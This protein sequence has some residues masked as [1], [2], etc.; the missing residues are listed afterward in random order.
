MPSLD[1]QLLDKIGA[2]A[3]TVDKYLD[4]LLPDSDYGERR[5]FDAMRY[6][7][8]GGGKRLRAF[9]LLSAGGMFNVAPECSYRAAAAIEMVH[10]YALV[11]DDLPA[12][13]DS[14]TRRGK[15]ATHKQ[16][17][18][19]T[20]ILAGDGLLTAA[21]E[22]LVDPATHSDPRIRLGLVECLAKA[23]GPNGMVGG[24]MLD[25]IA[26]TTQFDIGAIT[27]LQRMKT[28]EMIAASCVMGGILGNASPPQRQALVNYA[29]AVG[30]AFQIVDDLLDAEG[31]PEQMGKPARKDAVANK[32]TF[33]SVLGADR[34]RQQAQILIDQAIGHLRMFDGRGEDLEQIAQFVV[35]RSS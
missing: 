32:A 23:A 30:L 18:E 22:V 11:H 34:A 10:T 15:P 7:T 31:D 35:T 33:V 16:F 5:L 28:G 20:A 2:V 3:S 25:L 27:R 24:Q 13:D 9:M 6:A 19:A 14:D 1:P 21:F 17:D 4:K 29:H 26:E 12:M 8:L